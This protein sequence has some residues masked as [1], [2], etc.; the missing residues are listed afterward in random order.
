MPACCP[1]NSSLFP[2]LLANCWHRGYTAAAPCPRSSLRSCLCDSYRG[3]AFDSSQALPGPGRHTCHTPF[4]CRQAADK[5]QFTSF[6]QGKGVC[7]Y[8]SRN[9]WHW[10]CCFYT[11]IVVIL[12]RQCFSKYFSHRG[13]QEFA[14][15]SDT[16]L[17]CPSAV[18]DVTANVGQ[19]RFEFTDMY[20]WG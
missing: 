14:G 4:C 5:H 11:S 9:I 2:S 13:F 8:I 16:F 10:A 3:T 18:G 15:T 1:R 17:L 19:D 7:L 12:N 6:T 20:M